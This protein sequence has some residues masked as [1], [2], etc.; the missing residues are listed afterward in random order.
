MVIFTLFT[1]GCRTQEG[2]PDLVLDDVG[3]QEGNLV[4]SV[5]NK[6]NGS[7]PEDW[8]ALASVSIDGVVQQDI[9]LKDATSETEGGVAEPDGSSFY[10]TAFPVEQ[11]IR[12]DVALDYPDDIREADEDNN[13]V[14]NIYV[15]PCSLPDLI[16]ENLSLD[17]N[18]KLRIH[19]KN[20]GEGD[21]PDIAWAY[22]FMDNC[23][24]TIYKGDQAWACVPFISMDPSHALEPAGGTV[25]YT[26]D[27]EIQDETVV[28]VVVDSTGTVNESDERNNKWIQPLSCK[29]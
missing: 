12:V 19:L 9:F 22:E 14:N 20:Q 7:L 17:E 26:S 23:G 5:K 25:A 1:V 2:L 16:V 24:V 15:A 21:V 11:I 6:G 27:L 4:F 18:C 8:T 3:C 29:K 13:I 28:T 10:L